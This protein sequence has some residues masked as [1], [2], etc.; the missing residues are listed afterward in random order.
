MFSISPSAV[1]ISIALALVSAPI[2]SLYGAVSD[3]KSSADA[4]VVSIEARH[5]L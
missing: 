1:V 3:L 4:A 2:V 5:R